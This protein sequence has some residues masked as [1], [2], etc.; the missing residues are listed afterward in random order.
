MIHYFI[1][2][3][4]AERHCRFLK[5]NNQMDIDWVDSLDATAFKSRDE[6]TG[7]VNWLKDEEGL[8]CR[9]IWQNHETK[10]WGDL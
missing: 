5:T 6:A 4:G 8:C 10:E 7:M 3:V 1:L 2:K 9:A